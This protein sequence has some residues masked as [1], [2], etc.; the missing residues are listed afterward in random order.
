MNS[1]PRAEVTPATPARL[2]LS[3]FGAPFDPQ[4]RLELDATG[5]MEIVKSIPYGYRLRRIPRT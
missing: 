4:C 5:R 2:V 1:P 3:T